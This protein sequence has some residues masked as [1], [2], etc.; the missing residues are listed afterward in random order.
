M[1]KWYFP[2]L[3]MPYFLTYV[4]NGVYTTNVVVNGDFHAA[5]WHVPE[6]SNDKKHGHRTSLNNKGAL[7]VGN[8][9]MC[10]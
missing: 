4:L 8:Q 6:V 10:S 3:E 9:C 5:E 2:F 7:P 1:T